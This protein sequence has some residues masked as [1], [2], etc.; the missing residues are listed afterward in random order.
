MATYDSSKLI[1]ELLAKA[2]KTIRDRF[3]LIVQQIKNEHGLRELAELIAQ[4]DVEGALSILDDAAQRLASS[5]NAV[6][7]TVGTTTAD[8]VSDSL[9]IALSFDQANERAVKLLELNKL[10]LVRE[11]T[12]VQRDATRDALIQ[13]SRQG[14]NPREQARAFRDSIG[15]TKKQNR[16]VERYRELLETGDSEALTR[17]L[18]DA[19]FDKT[20]A[21]AIAEGKSLS[22]AEIKR[23]TERYRERMLKF[24]SETI[25]R[26]ESIATVN[27]GHDEAI[28]QGVDRGLLNAK[29]IQ[30]T[31][32]SAKDKRVR[33]PETGSTT[34]HRTMH[35]QVR[36]FGEPFV[37]GAGNLLRYPGD[38]QAPGIDRIQCRCVV[39]TRISL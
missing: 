4:G 34:S 37:S 1:E 22:K 13:G 20:V 6:F 38:A 35:N 2:H 12:E 30:R 31:W 16:A 5:I 9:G 7:L 28:R 27:Q 26:T 15:L 25:A 18:R 8:A 23:M 33:D 39:A 36:G 21:R 24:R 32:K 19:R 14:L 17:E 3:A 29:K 11:F 10:E